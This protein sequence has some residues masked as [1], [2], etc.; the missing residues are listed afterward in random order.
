MLIVGK[1]M[2][3]LGRFSLTERSERKV[4]QAKTW[5]QK[6]KKD[7]FIDVTNQKETIA[8]LICLGMMTVGPDKKKVMAWAG[9]EF[10]KFNKPWVKLFNNYW[11]N[12]TLG[13]YICQNKVQMDKDWKKSPDICLSLMICTALGYVKRALKEK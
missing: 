5:L 3:F 6:L 1:V 11:L 7:N 2:F 13:D 8:A 10:R 4:M 9:D 12:L